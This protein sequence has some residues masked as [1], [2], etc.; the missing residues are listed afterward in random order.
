M[1][2]PGTSC[3]DAPC[4]TCSVQLDECKE[5]GASSRQPEPCSYKPTTVEWD[6]YAEKCKK[7]ITPASITAAQHAGLL[8]PCFHDPIALSF[9]LWGWLNVNL[10]D[11]AW[12][13]LCTAER[14]QGLE[15]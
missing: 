2:Q 8:G 1:R 15:V 14:E 11:D 5:C 6:G 9:H 13:T 10:I 3:K 4:L 7:P 12:D